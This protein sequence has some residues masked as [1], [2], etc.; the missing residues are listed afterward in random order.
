MDRTR[1]YLRGFCA[2]LALTCV[3]AGHA[4]AHAGVKCFSDG[5]YARTMDVSKE[6]AEAYCAA[7][8][9]GDE[10]EDFS[11]PITLSPQSVTPLVQPVV[12][13][14]PQAVPAPAPIALIAGGLALLGGWR[15]R[16]SSRP[17]APATHRK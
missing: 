17:A 8:W 11:Q 4:P 16:R 14:T 13:S 5:S 10:E 1:P 3:I 12:E 9:A 6:E 2:S 15:K 7:Q